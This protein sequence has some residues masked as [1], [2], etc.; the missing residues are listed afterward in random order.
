M[1]VAFRF[2]NG[3][4]QLILVPENA[5]DK[6]YLSL[7]SD[8]RNNVRIKPTRDE[9]LIIEFGDGAARFDRPP[10]TGENDESI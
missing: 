1:K 6:Q 5:R 2:E 8:G 3:T 4:S 10:Q 7:C 9:V